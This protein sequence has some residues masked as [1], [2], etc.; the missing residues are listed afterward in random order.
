V[1]NRCRSRIRE[2]I[3]ERGRASDLAGPLY[4]VGSDEVAGRREDQAAIAHALRTLPR[5]QREVVACRYLLELTVVETAE[6]LGISDGAVKRHAYRGLQALH[7]A[8]EV[9]R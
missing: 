6:T 5:R 2:R 1:L 7:T 8:L 4:V 9:T 3:R